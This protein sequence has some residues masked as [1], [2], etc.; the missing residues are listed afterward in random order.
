MAVAHTNSLVSI[1]VAV[2]I[3]A[4]TS[5]CIFKY[6]IWEYPIEPQYSDLMVNY[7]QFIQ[8]FLASYQLHY[9]AL[10]QRY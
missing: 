6:T 7:S 9:S 4:K 2:G 8:D 5:T 1:I 10:Q 3:V